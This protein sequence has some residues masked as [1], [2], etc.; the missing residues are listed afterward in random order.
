MSIRETQQPEM[1]EKNTNPSIETDRFNLLELYGKSDNTSAKGASGGG[2][3]AVQS[4]NRDLE[5]AVTFVNST[6]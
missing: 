2:D 1:I 5:P 3:Q 6:G 4:N